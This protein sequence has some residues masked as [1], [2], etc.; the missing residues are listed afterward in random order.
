MVLERAPADPGL[1][2]DDRD[3]GSRPAVLGERRRCLLEL[4]GQLLALAKLALGWPL[5]AVAVDM[6]PPK[7]REDDGAMQR[8][9]GPTP[10]SPPD[11]SG[12]RR[13]QAGDDDGEVQA[14]V[15]VDLE[16]AVAHAQV[17]F[18]ADE[19]LHGVG[20][21]EQ[22]DLRQL[23]VLSRQHKE[24]HI[25]LIAQQRYKNL[26]DALA[27]LVGIAVGVAVARALGRGSAMMEG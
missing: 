2:G 15:L 14:G 6:D 20:R 11:R 9:F 26:L 24:L 25:R 27:D 22:A 13:A 8:R 1:L 5:T 21:D 23:L 10:Q 12:S 17:G 19:S 18:C 4:G 16:L 7:K 3:R